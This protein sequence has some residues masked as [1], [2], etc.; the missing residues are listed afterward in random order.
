MKNFIKIIAGLALCTS[1]VAFASDS[2]TSSHVHSGFYVGV[3]GA[4]GN[5]NAPAAA[6]NKTIDLSNK[7]S[8]TLSSA[9]PL[10]IKSNTDAIS[11]H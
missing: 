9:S 2:D 4:V 3:G 5:L 6:N 8:G 1:I 7:N 11:A 10:N